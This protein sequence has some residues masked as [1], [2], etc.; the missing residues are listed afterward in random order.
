[1]S[2]PTISSIGI[3]MDG[4]RRWARARGRSSSD[5]HRAGYDALL[6]LAREFPR[7]RD[8]YGLK[9]V[10]LYAFSTENWKRSPEEVDALLA[11]FEKG[12]DELGK[13]L[14]EMDVSVRA[15]GDTSR[16]PEHLQDLLRGI[17][18]KTKNNTAGTI[19]FAL[20]YGGREEL[21]HAAQTLIKEGG[22]VTEERFERALYTNGVPDLDLIVRTS[23][24]QRLSNFLPWQSTYSEFFFVDTLWPDFTVQDLE[25]IFKEYGERDRRRGA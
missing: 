14:H 4:N 10:T 20:S 21:V 13:R 9:Y 7:L 23:G 16:F 1:M 19:L 25:A 17:E 15:I 11:L 8:E 18:E 3:I 2:T 24:E 6:K 12:M 22:E 5:G